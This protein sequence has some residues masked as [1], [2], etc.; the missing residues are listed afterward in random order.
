MRKHSCKSLVNQP[1][2]NGGHFSSQGRSESPALTGRFALFPGQT[3]CQADDEL[4]G[5]ILVRKADQL[6]DGATAALNRVERRCQHPG[7]IGAGDPDAD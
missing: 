5:V 7:W 6:G 2:R 4:H 3:D 1:N